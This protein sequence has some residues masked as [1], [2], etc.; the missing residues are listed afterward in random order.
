MALISQIRK[1]FFEALYLKLSLLYLQQFEC[2][3]SY[4]VSVTDMKFVDTKSSQQHNG[5]QRTSGTEISFNLA[6][7]IVHSFWNPF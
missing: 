4:K 3:I 1:L 2:Y 7:V 5:N 6:T